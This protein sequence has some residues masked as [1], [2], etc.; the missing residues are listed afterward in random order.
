MALRAVLFINNGISFFTHILDSFFEIN[1]DLASGFLNAMDSFA[2]NVYGEKLK[3]N[4]SWR[5]FYFEFG[6]AFF[7]ITGQRSRR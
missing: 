4:H 7:F 1:V 6:C 3:I 2:S 5:I